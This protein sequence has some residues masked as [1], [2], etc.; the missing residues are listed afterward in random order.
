MIKRGLS[1]GTGRMRLMVAFLLGLSTALGS[2]EPTKEQKKEGKSVVVD[3]ITFAVREVD[4][5]YL[6]QSLAMDKLD[7]LLIEQKKK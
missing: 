4:S 6:K 1:T 2:Q 5:I 7:S 3:T